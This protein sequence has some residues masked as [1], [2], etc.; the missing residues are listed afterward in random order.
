VCGVAQ[1]QPQRFVTLVAVPPSNAEIVRSTCRAFATGDYRRA[2]RWFAAG[3]EWIPPAQF[4]TAGIYRG[5]R[6]V[7]TWFDQLNDVYG[8]FG[9]EL[10]DLI[11]V[12]ENRVIA[13][14]QVHAQG[15]ASGLALDEEWAHV[16]TLRDARA[17]RIEMFTSRR[18]ALDAVADSPVAPT[19]R[20]LHADV[21]ASRRR[22]PTPAVE[23]A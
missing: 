18:D 17:V 23:L 4:P 14:M 20:R 16:W 1:N 15:R 9:G 21:H 2:C 6:G 13:V 12:G 8:S 11:D 22:R 7:F 5:V 19:V 3:I 10:V